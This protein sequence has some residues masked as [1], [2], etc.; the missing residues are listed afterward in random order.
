M[1]ARLSA[2]ALFAVFG[3]LPGV[4]NGDILVAGFEADKVLQYNSS[5]GVVGV[6]AERPTLMEMDG[7]T[8][9][10][11]NT[12]GHLLVLNEFSKN[13]LEFNGTTGT[14]V[15]EVISSATL[16][17]NGITDPADME[18]GADGNLYF[19]N[20]G[21]TG[22]TNIWKYNSTSGAITAF[23]TSGMP[24]HHTHG[25]AF[26]PDGNLYQ[27][28][29]T[30]N[31]IMRFN[32]T[33][34]AFMGAFPVPPR[35]DLGTGADLIFGP[36]GTLYATIDGAGG[37]LRFSPAGVFLGYLIAPGPGLATWGLMVDGGVLYVGGRTVG[38]AFVKRFDATTE[39]FIDNFIT[40]SPAVFDMLILPTAVPEVGAAAMMSLA[41]TCVGAVA[42]LRRRRRRGSK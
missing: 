36:T 37:V 9:M 3:Q 25:L 2:L 26:G 35:S 29:L 24:A 23:A 12:A 27:I 40:G 38:S 11:Y 22:G 42:G 4:C 39:A 7:P 5:G 34:G 18:I 15:G 41:A 31:N 20:H 30:N 1:K 6:F 16:V 28:D 19:T 21:S 14:Y 8:A 17:A 13:V 33:T 10:V 32:G